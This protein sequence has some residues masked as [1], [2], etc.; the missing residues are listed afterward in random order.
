MV[1]TQLRRRRGYFFA[2]PL[3]DPPAIVHVFLV[4]SAGQAGGASI[5]SV[6]RS[7]CLRASPH[8]VRTV[9][10]SA[11]KYPRLRPK[12]RL[13]QV[14]RFRLEGAI[15]SMFALRENGIRAHPHISSLGRTGACFFCWSDS[16]SAS[17]DQP[18]AKV[19]RQHAERRAV[20]LPGASKLRKSI[21]TER[22]V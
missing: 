4:T 10:P 13:Q 12:L 3:N 11:K 20:G 1:T 15:T 16:L 2:A 19:T 7:F 14:G 18:G 9:V 22:V 17:E 6:S 8:C 5:T 21:L